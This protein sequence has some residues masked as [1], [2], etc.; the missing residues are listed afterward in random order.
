MMI[1]LWIGSFLLYS[2]RNNTRQRLLLRSVEIN[3]QSEGSLTHGDARTKD[4]WENLHSQ[5]RFLPKYPCE[6]VVRYAFT[7]L[8]GQAS[9]RLSLKVLDLGCGGG[10]HTQFLAREGF[11]TFALDFSL[12]GLRQTAQRL[13]AEGLDA[14]LIRA[15]MHALPFSSESFDSVIAYGSIYYTD[16]SGLQRCI[17]E[18]YRVLK[19]DGTTFVFTRTSDDCRFG[20]GIALDD[21]TF[22]FDSNKTNEEGMKNC[23]LGMEDVYQFFGNFMSVSLDKLEATLNN[24]SVLNSDWLIVASK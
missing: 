14:S 15:D 21:R 2:V 17:D 18:I 5:P 12:V 3:M 1:S 8:A 20:N 19:P 23:F 22:L 6:S 24:G 13:D 7:R 11:S 16:T 10:R 9:E 4:R